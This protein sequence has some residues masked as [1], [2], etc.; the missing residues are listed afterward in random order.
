MDVKDASRCCLLIFAVFCTGEE[1]ARVLRAERGMCPRWREGEMLC[2]F[3]KAGTSIA[4][5][6]GLQIGRDSPTR[7]HLFSRHF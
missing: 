7:H 6:S 1:E 2:A 3:R 4:R 5:I